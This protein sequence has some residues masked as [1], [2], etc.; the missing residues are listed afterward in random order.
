MVR[1]NFV[2]F[3]FS[4]CCY[5]FVKKFEENCLRLKPLI[6]VYSAFCFKF[7]RYRSYKL[8]IV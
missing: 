5:D 8:K 3:K 6:G 1:G 2:L 7:V 4:F